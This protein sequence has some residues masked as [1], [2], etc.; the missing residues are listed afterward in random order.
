MFKFN[1]IKGYY[2]GIPQEKNGKVIFE[3][4]E[5]VFAFSEEQAIKHYKKCMKKMYE[6]EVLETATVVLG[7]HNKNVKD[8]FGVYKVGLRKDT[9]DEYAKNRQEFYDMVITAKNQQ[10]AIKE[11]IVKRNQKDGH[12]RNH[13]EDKEYVT[14]L[15]KL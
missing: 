2:I 14:I 7:T 15:K 11:Y 10:E 5:K 8:G 13:K 9:E 6:P 1:F 4:K 12:F 3:G